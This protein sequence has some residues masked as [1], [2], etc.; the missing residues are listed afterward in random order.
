M[1]AP[2]WIGVLLGQF[3]AGEHERAGRKLDLVMALHHQHL[4]FVGIPE[5]QNGG[6]GDDRRGHALSLTA[7]RGLCTLPC[8]CMSYIHFFVELAA[9]AH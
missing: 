6:G 3:P 7:R 2:G 1:T 5:H 9:A 8:D 4:Q